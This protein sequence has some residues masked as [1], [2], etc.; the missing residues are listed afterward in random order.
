MGLGKLLPAT[1]VNFH[2]NNQVDSYGRWHLLWLLNTS[3]EWKWL[4][5]ISPNICSAAKIYFLRLLYPVVPG[6]YNLKNSILLTFSIFNFGMV[7]LVHN[8]KLFIK[9][10]VFKLSLCGDKSDI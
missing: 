1:I 5:V 2:Q 4:N 6:C 8:Q 7:T 3:L 10:L 9:W